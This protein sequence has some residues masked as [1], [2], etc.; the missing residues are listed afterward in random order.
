MASKHRKR[1]STLLIIREMQ[2]RT[3]MR[4]HLTPIK[5]AIIKKSTNNKLE[6]TWRKGNTLALLV[7]L[8]TDIA[9]MEDGMEILKKKKKN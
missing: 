4:Y 5:L 3:T 9:N 8:Q 2:I 6:S 1:C 7:G